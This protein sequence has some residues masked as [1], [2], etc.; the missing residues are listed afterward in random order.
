MSVD[1]LRVT[2]LKT[3]FYTE[4]GVVQAVDGV[5]LHLGRG[6]TLGIV[7]ESGSGKSVTS[8]SILRLISQPGKIVEGSVVFDGADLLHI[9][10]EAMRAIRGNRI[11]MIFQQPTTA[12]NPVFRVGDQITETLEI[13]QGLR[14]D[15]ASK[16]CIELLSMVGLPDAPRRMRQFPH[17]LS[18]GQCQRVMIAMALAC[19]PELLIADEPTT[20]LD[21]TIQAQ[22]LDLMR[23][24]REKVNTAIILITHDMGVVAEMADS[25][26]VMYAGQIIEYADVRSIFA[27]PKHPYT[28]GLLH[29]M[30]VLG[31][32]R[33][34]LEVI[35]GTVPSLIGPPAG[36]RF[37]AHTVVRALQGEANIQVEIGNQL[38]LTDIIFNVTDP[39]NCP[40]DD[41]KCTGHPALRDV[42]VRQ[43]LAHATDKQQLIDTVLL[44]L[45]TPGL[46]L[47]TPGQGEAYA[48]ELQDYAFDPA[49]ANQ[50]LDDAGYA[51][52]DGDGVREMPGDPSQ[53]LTFRY[54]YPSDQSANGQRIFELLRDMW[55]QV[56]VKIELTPLDADALT[57]VC[58]PA[59]D[60][61]VINWGWYAGVDP[62]SLLYI[63]TT[64]EIPTGNSETG[65]GNPEYDKLY[66]E[67]EVTVDVAKRR[68]LLA[69]MQQILLRD[70]PYIIPYYAQNVEA[71][72]KDRFQGWVVDPEGVLAL[73]SRISLTAVSPIK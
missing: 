59:F 29:S 31:H 62:S 55:Q 26:A 58:C 43:A 10:D 16:R 65:Y 21:V 12:L 4:D 14:G 46:T 33:D 72:R 9:G 3:Y 56:G 61:D 40:P 37:A 66:A 30:P 47:V 64:A 44:G 71:Y 13:H 70:V 51:D 48:K 49:K 28:Q 24:L 67:Q 8:L 7:G 35:P 60:F 20:A 22:I 18:G 6:E 19:N 45:G 42:K 68:E 32:V 54:N 41:G 5:D 25:V 53:P 2:G 23:G 38:G 27:D 15:E 57:S 39:A 52:S 1:L 73:S 36:C 34:E 69:Q 63:A 17:E 11:S 50:I